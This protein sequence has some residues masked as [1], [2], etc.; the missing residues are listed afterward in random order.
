MSV[1]KGNSPEVK[2][3]PSEEI[4]SA[5][6][7]SDGVIELPPGAVQIPSTNTIFGPAARV[8]EGVTFEEFHHWALE[9][10]EEEIRD[11]EAYLLKQ[12][13]WSFKKMIAARFSSGWREPQLAASQDVDPD[14]T[15][16]SHAISVVEKGSHDN[17][18][19]GRNEQLEAEWKTASRALKTAS[20]G[21]VFYLITTDILGW[22]GAPFTFSTVGFGPGAAL[23]TVFGVLAGLSGVM[24]WK[25]FLGLSSSRYPM[26]SFGDT[27]YRV[28]GKIP[29]HLI[30]I[31]Q[32]IQQFMSVAV[33]VLGNAQ[34]LAQIVE[35]ANKSLCFIV[36]MIVVMVLG[37]LTGM[38]RSLNHVGWLANASVWMNIARYVFN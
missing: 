2:P 36:A 18:E 13:P 14:P 20:W 1:E 7:A 11:N 25:V 34:S 22:S 21:S 31:W 26:S 29:R 12:G 4:T 32:S 15:V 27:Y 17:G 35:G 28:Y 6:V 9:E 16:S 8:P 24:I 19:R 23:Y 30:N 10:R 3:V 38:M 33:L 37:M 5:E